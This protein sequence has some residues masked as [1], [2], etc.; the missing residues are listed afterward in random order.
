MSDSEDEIQSRT[1]K[2]TV[3]GEP[4]TGKVS[5]FSFMCIIIQFGKHYY[6]YSLAVLF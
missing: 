2:I 6:L 4:A 5:L 3:V 1:I